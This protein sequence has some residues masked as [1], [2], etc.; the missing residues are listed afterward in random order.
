MQ[1]PKPKNNL[2]HNSK[3]NQELL[4]SQRQF[5]FHLQRRYQL[6]SPGMMHHWFKFLHRAM[7]LK[8]RNHSLQ[9][10]IL[11]RMKW[12]MDFILGRQFNPDEISGY[13]GEMVFRESDIIIQQKIDKHYSHQIRTFATWKLIPYFKCWFNQ[14]I[15]EN[16]LEQIQLK[17]YRMSLHSEY[18]KKIYQNETKPSPFRIIPGNIETIGKTNLKGA[19]LSAES[20][21]LKSQSF[22]FL[23][24]ITQSTFNTIQV[25][26]EKAMLT[27]FNGRDTIDHPGKELQR[28]PE[29]YSSFETRPDKRI[30]PE[31]IHNF[32]TVSR[33]GTLTLKTPESNFAF[34]ELPGS[35]IFE[36]K[37]IRNFPVTHLNLKIQSMLHEI[38]R[39]RRFV[40]S[41]IFPAR[42]FDYSLRELQFGIQVFDQQWHTKFPGASKPYNSNTRYL[43][44]LDN[45]NLETASAQRIAS[46]KIQTRT[47]EKKVTEAIQ[48]NN[49]QKIS[50]VT[51]Q[52]D[53]DF[54]MLSH[55]VVGEFIHSRAELARKQILKQTATKFSH[56]SENLSTAVRWLENKQKQ[57]I[58]LK[59]QQTLFPERQNWGK[60]P[61]TIVFNNSAR[62]QFGLTRQKNV[63]TEFH[64][65]KTMMSNAL[66]TQSANLHFVRQAEIVQPVSQNFIYPQSSQKS[67]ENVVME[68]QVQE[69]EVERIVKKEIETRMQS[70]SPLE[71]FTRADFSKLTDQVYSNLTRRLMQEKERFG[72]GY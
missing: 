62:D 58:L 7:L 34:T 52:S 51:T 4:I 56:W 40:Q 33:T 64:F 19:G 21:R 59:N 57:E 22:K 42:E 35:D 39:T 5:A 14:T 63:S 72:R 53:A 32:H 8:I 50:P 12:F 3:K 2:A 54:E 46:K 66:P 10:D 41:I 23:Q 48:T 70:K 67:V 20:I 31:S 45:R 11:Y 29:K 25:D 1:Y 44:L 24:F 69:K 38:K 65:Y 26:S 27:W 17:N 71:N 36:R 47:V 68:R 49:E 43:A 18:C 9:S 30:K 28:H 13:L 15:T 6:P 37:S 16:L 61:Q 60:G 55:K